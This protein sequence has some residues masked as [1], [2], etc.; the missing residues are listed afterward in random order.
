MTES[1]QL[2]ALQPKAAS[3]EVSAER[4][5]FTLIAMVLGAVLVLLGVWVG[6]KLSE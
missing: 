1:W 4:A 5:A 6:R 3:E 2:A